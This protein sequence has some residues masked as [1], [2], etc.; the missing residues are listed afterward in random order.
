[1]KHFVFERDDSM[2]IYNILHQTDN[3]KPW[4]SDTQEDGDVHDGHAKADLPPGTQGN[5]PGAKKR[6]RRADAVVRGASH[7]VGEDTQNDG[8]NQRRCA[9][10]NQDGQKRRI[11]CS[12]VRRTRCEEVVR[13]K[14]QQDDDQK[15]RLPGQ[16]HTTDDFNDGIRKPRDQ[17]V[18][19]QVRGHRNQR[20]KPGQSIPSRTF[21]QALF[22]GDD[23]GNEQNGQAVQ[24]G[25]NRA[26]ADGGAKDPK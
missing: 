12:N 2:I 7:N 19:L 16:A 5:V 24:R 26:D 11:H 4:K 8:R 25:C 21:S 17:T 13:V 14:V 20:G 1:M 9:A 3:L 23:P 22:P 6:R 10:G 18:F 15:R